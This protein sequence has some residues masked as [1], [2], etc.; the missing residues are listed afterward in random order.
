MGVTDIHLSVCITALYPSVLAS[1]FSLLQPPVLSNVTPRKLNL[2]ASSLFCQFILHLSFVFN[3]PR[4]L[5]AIILDLLKL[6]FKFK[7]LQYSSTSSIFFCNPRLVE[8]GVATSS[9]NNNPEIRNLFI[10]GERVS[11]VPKYS[12]TFFTKILYKYE[13]RPQP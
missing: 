10:N 4:F 3:Y 8:D 6:H 13:L 5:N 7:F 2:S 1:V 12:V 11:S 9:A